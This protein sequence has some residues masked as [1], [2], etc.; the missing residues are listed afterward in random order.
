[1][2]EAEALS[3]TIEEQLR[4]AGWPQSGI[5]REPLLPFGRERYRPSF[6]LTYSMYPLAALDLVLP[7]ASPQGPERRS[8]AMPETPVLPIMLETDGTYTWRRGETT[9]HRWRKVPSPQEL[10]ALLGREWRLDDP[11]LV[12][13]NS[14]S[15]ATFHQAVAIGKTLDALIAGRRLLQL[16]M[17]IGTGRLRITK[18]LVWKLLRARRCRR[19]LYIAKFR[20]ET[21]QARVTFGELAP[22]LD[23]VFL[24][25]PVTYSRSPI[26]VSTA[27]YFLSVPNRLES[28]PRDFYDLLL[29]PDLSDQGSW[30]PIAE[31][32]AE[33]IVIGFSYSEGQLSAEFERPVFKL[34]IDDILESEEPLIP[35][36]FRQ[37]RLGEIAE[38]TRGLNL[39]K[40]EGLR[41]LRASDLL[42]ERAWAV[43]GTPA[44]ALDP[45]NEP[46]RIRPSDIL[47]AAIQIPSSPLVALVPES[48]PA[49]LYLHSSL[50]RIRIINNLLRPAD[51]VAFLKSEAGSRQLQRVAS[52]LGGHMRLSVL[53]LEQLG[54]LVPVMSSGGADQHRTDAQEEVPVQSLSAPAQAIQQLR[55]IVLP[56]LEELAA[57]AQSKDPQVVAARLREIAASLAKPTLQERVM[58]RFPL[59]I[60]LA[61]RRLHD[62]RFNIY[63]Q[64]L[65]LRDLFEAAGFFIFNTVLADTFHRL[66]PVEPFIEERSV[67]TAFDGSSMSYRV[68]FVEAVAEVVRTR[69]SQQLF[70]PELCSSKFTALARQIQS[71]FR[72][73]ISHSATASESRQKALLDRYQPIVEE[74]LEELSFLENYRLARI[75]AIYMKGGRYI[76]RVEIYQGVT[77]ALD[78]QDFG[79]ADRPTLAEHD[80]LVLL[81]PSDEYLD[82]YPLY[83][84][85]ASAST[86]YET[87][88]C[89]FRQRRSGR[90]EGES[91]LNSAAVELNGLS[92]FDALRRRLFH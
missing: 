77:P 28:F 18:E 68:A 88:M 50:C 59:P 23:T 6:V 17:P 53:S 13:P 3:A 78:E 82:L 90:L 44:A 89:F 43:G 25:G 27:A 67:R 48:I 15:G 71:E 39:P 38:I 34:S 7:T 46:Y 33:S 81:N 56:E 80:H 2:N 57:D 74:M 86:S 64:V 37:V 51:V 63:E 61:Y 58:T 60:A 73:Q 42:Y 10:W 75:A 24:S 41:V 11:R 62:S 40:A 12:T 35:V 76:R 32:F 49:D 70:L 72:N 8:Y 47:V 85:V 9:G 55:S 14:N 36:G 54:V 19:V 20:V 1:M 22:A 30:R 4:S 29:V 16:V 84:H 92:D 52:F 69:A 31:R 79:P 83:Q 45:Q 66:D 87:H 91:V 21:E 65:R 5:I 26:H